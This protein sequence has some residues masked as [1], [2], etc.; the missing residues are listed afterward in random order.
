[1]DQSFVDEDNKPVWQWPYSAFGANKPTGILQATPNPRVAITNQP[2]LFKAPVFE[3]ATGDRRIG[4]IAVFSGHV[5]IYGGETGVR[6]RDIFS[7][8]RTGGPVF[9]PSNSSWF[10]NPVWYRFK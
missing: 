4:N 9:G 7:A 2:V 3:P 5:S 6:N 1:M 8:S 10:G